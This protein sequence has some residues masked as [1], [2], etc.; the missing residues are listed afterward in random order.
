MKKITISAVIVAKNEEDKIKNCLES[1]KWV[2]EIIFIDNESTD[3]TAE[4]AKKYTSKFY[5][6]NGGKYDASLHNK[7]FG[8]TK[9]SG[10]WI[11]SVDADE[12]LTDSC[13]QEILRKIKENQYDSFYFNFKPFFFGKEFVGPLWTKTKIIRLFKKNKGVYSS[14][15]SHTP[16]DVQGKIGR[17]HSPIYHYGYPDIET[18]IRKMN[19]Y[20]TWSANLSNDGQ[21]SGLLAKN[22]GRINFYYLFIE[23][24][25]FL[26]HYFIFR[27][28]YKDGIYGLVLSVL[29]TFYLFVE[30]AKLWKLQNDKRSNEKRV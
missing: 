2:D 28:N 18:F 27:K 5:I 6:R 9:A 29:V 11:L 3:K 22:I 8:F 13:K 21:K 4:I 16:L 7:N 26:P 23:P 10:E 1:I 17:I 12:V 19:L 24:A 20:T 25:L 14:L 15:D 30:R